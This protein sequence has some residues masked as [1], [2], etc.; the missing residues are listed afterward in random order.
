MLAGVCTSSSTVRQSLL[1]AGR[2]AKKPLQNH[3][4]TKKMKKRLEWAR[5]HKNWTVE[6]WKKVLFQTKV[7]FS[8]KESTND[9]P[10]SARVNI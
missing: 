2:K 5:A 1:E 7:I 10:K 6:D 9:L 3:L 4:L 8:F